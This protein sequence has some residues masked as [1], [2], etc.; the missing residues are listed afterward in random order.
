MAYLANLTS[1]AGS[2]GNLYF[3]TYYAT[4]GEPPGDGSHPVHKDYHGYELLASMQS[5]EQYPPTH[6]DLS[7][8]RQVPQQLHPAV[9][10][11]PVPRLPGRDTRGI[12]RQ[13]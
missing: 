7:S 3:E 10:Q 8:C 11:L 12:S 5:N 2:K 6:E 1:A 4:S 13:T 9:L